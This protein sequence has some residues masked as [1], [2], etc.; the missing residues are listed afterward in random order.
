M[1]THDDR[2]AITHLIAEFAW[3]IDH[4]DGHG[5]EDLFTDDGAY[6]L[7]GW[8]LEGRD[9]IKGFYDD[10]RSRGPRTSRHVYDNVRITDGPDDRTAHVSSILTLHAADG[11][12]PLP[13]SLL[14]V[15]DY[16]DTLHR[17]DDGT[18]RFRRRDTTLVFEPASGL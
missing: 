2:A 5:V 13:L 4:G 12:P 16:L 6:V 18:W 7:F 17:D 11:E 14:M 1:L 10:R 15:A 9:S 8:P 3:R